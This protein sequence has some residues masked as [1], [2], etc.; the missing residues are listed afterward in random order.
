M[1]IKLSDDILKQVLTFRYLGSTITSKCE[2]DAEINSQIGAAAAVFGRLNRRVF[3]S[4][5][6]KLGTKADIYRAVVLPN[7]LYSSESWTIY[8]RHI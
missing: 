2:L 8:R 3:S 1:A 4:H 5:N 7:M 6:L